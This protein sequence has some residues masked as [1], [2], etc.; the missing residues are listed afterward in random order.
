MTQTLNRPQQGSPNFPPAGPE[1]NANDD[2]FS[3]FAPENIEQLREA[4]KQARQ[5]EMDNVDP[6]NPTERKAAEARAA[7]RY[8]DI[9]HDYA[10]DFDFLR[11]MEGLDP[12]DPAYDDYQ[13]VMDHLGQ[14]SIDQMSDDEWQIGQTAQDGT[15]TPSGR[16]QVKQIHD[17][18]LRAY[19]QASTPRPT[20]PNNSNDDTIVSTEMQQEITDRL[21]RG[22]RLQ[23]ALTAARDKLAEMALKRQGKM[24]DVVSSEYKQAYQ[25]YRDAMIAFGKF[26][27]ELEDLKNAS[28]TQNEKNISAV[29]YLIEE[30]EKLRTLTNEKWGNTK[31]GKLCTWLAKGNF[32]QRTLKGVG[33]GL[34]AAGTA[35]LV[36][37]TTAG[38]GTLGVAAGGGAT[39]VTLA[40]RLMRG[41]GAVRGRQG[42]M[43]GE[44][45]RAEAGELMR[46]IGIHGNM[47]DAG[48]FITERYDESVGNERRKN[49]NAVAWGMG[50]VVVGA[51]LAEFV[52]LA[53]DH[54]TDYADKLH[55]SWGAVREAMG[56]GPNGA[57]PHEMPEG[58]S[59]G[60]GKAIGDLA[61]Q[62]DKD[63][64]GHSDGV[65]P[66]GEV[67][68][69]ANVG[70]H[71]TAA[72]LEAMSDI[73]KGMGGIQ[74]FKEMGLSA[75][76]WYQHEEALLKAHPDD[77]YR[78]ADGH[79]GLQHPG[80]LS[81]DAMTDIAKRTGI[82]RK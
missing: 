30:D 49:R 16:D 46:L 24:L 18:Q 72:Q 21:E 41:Y 51:S 63:G 77:F 67:A 50:S 11:G 26:N 35:A 20:N 38:T 52:H 45:S 75:G 55:S 54:A 9:I 37:A 73:D 4:Q 65:G 79:V 68:P 81:E 10:S 29:G 74:L 31:V 23:K 5:E 64:D 76:D 42:G 14:V 58:D 69:E 7:A 12:S 43:A 36:T 17:R 53:A 71:I 3:F 61:E 27:E 13:D 15:H 66:G 34:A 25:E 80:K 1:N 28:R 60:I 39:V 32:A 44:L 6:F 70:D 57:V 78:M 62:L 47:D 48:H 56:F 40:T 8:Q 82:W 59:S 2:P 22:D 19:R 33:L